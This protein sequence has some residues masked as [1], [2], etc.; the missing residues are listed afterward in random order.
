M[1][2]PFSVHFDASRMSET[3]E[4]DLFGA[5]E[6]AG[7]GADERD[8]RRA[9]AVVECNDDQTMRCEGAA[10][11]GVGVFRAAEAVGEDGDGPAVGGGEERGGG[12]GRDGGVE[13]ETEEREVA[14]LIQYR[15]SLLRDWKGEEKKVQRCTS[16]DWRAMD[17]LVGIARKLQSIHFGAREA[18]RRV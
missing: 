9:I 7:P 10:E 4:V 14:G 17:W 2:V 6:G 13:E 5:F 11:G 1:L 18:S 12:D 16:I 15:R 3:P 8:R